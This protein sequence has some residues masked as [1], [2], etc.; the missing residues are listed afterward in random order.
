MKPA[1]PLTLL[2]AG[3]EWRVIQAPDYR[4]MTGYMCNA[5]DDEGGWL[6]CGLPCVATRETTDTGRLTKN[7]YGEPRCERHLGS[8]RW[9]EGDRVMQWRAVTP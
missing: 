9:V 4:V 3:R 1:P 5:S 7:L 8:I 6:R 2:P